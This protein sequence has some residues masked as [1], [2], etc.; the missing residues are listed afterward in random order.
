MPRATYKKSTAIAVRWAIVALV[1]TIL[2][3]TVWSV[4]FGSVPTIE[5]YSILYDEGRTVSISIS[6]NR[7]LDILFVPITTM[8]LWP[9]AYLTL[10]S[11]ANFDN[12]PSEATFYRK[13]FLGFLIAFFLGQLAV[14]IL[15]GSTTHGVFLAVGM[16]GVLVFTFI[17]SQGGQRGEGAV[18][19]I[20]SLIGITLADCLY[21]GFGI[22]LTA[23]FIVSLPPAFFLI[24]FFNTCVG[25]RAGL[26]PSIK[27][28]SWA[29]WLIA[30]DME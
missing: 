29:R 24:L 19:G 7:W 4:I 11:A 27:P 9:L 13:L 10:Y 17:F 12:K 21:T 16:F 18:T 14:L 25:I 15:W 5:S 30:R 2:F 3:W 28:R 22:G 20:G 8:T 23:A 26:I 6:Y 1:V